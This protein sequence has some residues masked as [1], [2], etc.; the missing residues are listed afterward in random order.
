M[1]NEGAVI[2]LS[3]WSKENPTLTVFC[4]L[5]FNFCASHKLPVTRITLNYRPPVTTDVKRIPAQVRGLGSGDHPSA[6]VADARSG[7]CL[8]H[9]S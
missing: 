7:E 1:K 2:H 6:G 4:A 9:T 5:T 3:G 8:T